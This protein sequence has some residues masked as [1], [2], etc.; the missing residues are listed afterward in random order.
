MSEERTH[1]CAANAYKIEDTMSF[2]KT[3]CVAK[4]LAHE[5][6]N[7]LC[8]DLE[9]LVVIQRK[10]ANHVRICNLVKPEFDLFDKG[11]FH[12]RECCCLR[13]SNIREGNKSE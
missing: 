1:K 3:V 4:L 7:Y 11:V 12:L 8:Y 9:N 13:Q 5:K 6:P 2:T 10:E